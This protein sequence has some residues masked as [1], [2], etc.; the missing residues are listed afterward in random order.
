[1]AR[2]PDGLIVLGPGEGQAFPAMDIVRKSTAADG[3]G[4]W[5]VA[6]VRGVPGEGGRTHVHRGEAEGFYVLEGEVEFLGATSTTPMRSG[7]FAL[8][9]PDTEHGIRIVGSSPAAWL[10]V[11][12]AMLDGL[13]EELERLIAAGADPA[14]IRVLRRHHG[15][16]PGR[17]G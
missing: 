13:P 1:M 5:G 8:V 9:P 7:S 4:R 11:W 12:P 15:V 17:R 14:E 6:V 10:A 2:T 16:T 3:D